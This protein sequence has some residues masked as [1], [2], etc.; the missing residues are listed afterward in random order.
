MNSKIFD[1]WDSL[2]PPKVE[3]KKSVIN[4]KGTNA[5]LFKDYLGTMGF[6]LSGVSLN[7]KFPN[8]ENLKIFNKKEKLVEQSGMPNLRLK[9]CLEIHLEPFCDSNLLVRILD[10]L[11]NEEPSG[12]FDSSL[13]LD[14]IKRV[15]ELVKRPQKP[16]SKQEVIGAWG[17]LLLLHSFIKSSDSQY[18]QS[19][20]IMGWEASPTNRS[21]ID[22]MF[23]FLG[24]GIAMEVKTSSTGR[25][26]HFHG[27]PQV[28]VPE[29]FNHGM[30]AS[31]VILE[32]ES[33]G[34]TCA[35]LV[36]SIKEIFIGTES[37]IATITGD[38]VKKLLTRG[39]ATFDER[40]RFIS[41]ESS[42]RFVEMPDVPRPI[43]SP[44]VKDV[45]WTAELENCIVIPDSTI[46]TIFPEVLS[47]LL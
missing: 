47:N 42:L 38:F 44:G 36:S 22:F 13:L 15:L 43:L 34:K 5:W 7:E 14:V 6:L 1:Q 33:T 21:I 4:V 18:Q 3:N 10:T 29:G 24:N 20:L 35:D 46:S 41:N 39:S 27:I 23:P 40:F 25:I 11:S 9:N 32:N 45:E 12:R 19:R 2:S 37:E 8:F 26:H 31:L 30:V 28:T 16:P 17:E